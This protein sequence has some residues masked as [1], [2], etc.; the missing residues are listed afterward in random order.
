MRFGAQMD[1]GI[2]CW[3]SS[4]IGV[5][6][7]FLRHIQSAHA[8]MLFL[9]IIISHFLASSQEIDIIANYAVI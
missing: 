2:D 1:D 3:V 6:G 7:L 4:C 8:H 5:K 9:P